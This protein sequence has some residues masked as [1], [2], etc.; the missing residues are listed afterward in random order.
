VTD[1]PNGRRQGPPAG[2]QSVDRWLGAG[3]AGVEVE[4]AAFDVAAHTGSRLSEALY[5]DWRDVDL[6]GARVIYWPEQTK[7][8][9]RRKVELPR[10]GVRTR[11]GMFSNVSQQGLKSVG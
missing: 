3:F 7:S 2:Q 10:A 8:E 11:N 5:L 4:P 9:K 6:E 1:R